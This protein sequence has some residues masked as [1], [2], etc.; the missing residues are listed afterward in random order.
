MTVD[1][2]S[3]DT[4]EL[5]LPATVVIPAGQTS[6]MFDLTIVDDADRDGLQSVSVV[7]R[8]HGFSD[9]VASLVVRDNEVNQIL[10]DVLDGPQADAVAFAA[11]ARAIN[12]DGE[13]ILVHHAPATLSAVG[14]GGAL[15]V[16]PDSCAFVDGLWTGSVTIDAVDSDVVLTLDDGA[17]NAGASNSFDVVAGPAASFEW[18]TIASP[19]Y[20]N[21]LIAATLIAKDVNGYTATNFNGTA[22]LSGW[23][24]NAPT[25]GAPTALENV[26]T[27]GH[28][29]GVGRQRRWVPNC[30]GHNVGRPFSQ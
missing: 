13:T 24:S 21:G 2:T 26:K 8:G 19:Q 20:E 30:S 25:L 4:G 29:P 6:A 11:T 10:W 1:L 3:D 14:R 12:I 7:A 15:P 23:T 17:G 16:S 5:Q 28:R 22:A 27:T 9:A 18:S